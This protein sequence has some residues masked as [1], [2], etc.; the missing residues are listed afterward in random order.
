M[1]VVSS[2][3]RQVTFHVAFMTAINQASIARLCCVLRR[4][5]DIFTAKHVLATRVFIIFYILAN[6]LFTESFKRA[7]YA[8]TDGDPSTRDIILV[9]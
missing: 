1:V 7:G 3:Q 2:Q 8:R 9:I 6:Y 4:N 5:T